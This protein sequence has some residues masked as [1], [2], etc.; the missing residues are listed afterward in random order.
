MT[1]LH[2]KRKFQVEGDIRTNVCWYQ[3]TR[4]ITLSC[5]IKIAAVCFVTKHA[6]DGRTDRQNYDHQ[7]S[8]S[9]AASRGNNYKVLSKRLKDTGKKYALVSFFGSD[10]TSSACTYITFHQ[11]EP[12]CVQNYLGGNQGAAGTKSRRR[13]D[14]CNKIVGTVGYSIAQ[15]KHSKPNLNVYRIFSNRSPGFY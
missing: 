3:K 8:A 9:I 10:C 6:C 14:G 2:F 7:D 4:V 5:L 1:T 13:G 12:L 11:V 15:Q